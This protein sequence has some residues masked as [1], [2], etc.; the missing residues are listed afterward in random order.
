MGRTRQ[1]AKFEDYRDQE[2]AEIEDIDLENE[3]NLPNKALFRVDEVA[4]YF[5]VSSQTI[6]LW[7]E[8]GLLVAEKYRGTIRIPRIAIKTFRLASRIR[9][10]D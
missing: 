5:D 4:A 7:I 9:P 3:P 1:N 6:Y 8:H 10:F 2:E